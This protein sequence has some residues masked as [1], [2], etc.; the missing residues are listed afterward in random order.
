MGRPAG[1]MQKLTGRGAMRSPSAPSIRC[2]IERR[3]W[4]QI[5]TGITSE[6]AAE[7]VGVSPVIGA[8]WFRHRGGMPL[9]MSRL[10]LT[11]F[12]G[13]IWS[14]GFRSRLFRTLR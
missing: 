2:E 5:A 3:F 6:R 1:W 14:L 10:E 7:A 4:Q 8:R 9:F 11:R 12:R 13:H